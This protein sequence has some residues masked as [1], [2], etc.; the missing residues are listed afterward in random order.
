M[1]RNWAEANGFGAPD[2]GGLGIRAASFDTAPAGS[3][4]TARGND[5]PAECFPSLLC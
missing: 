5:D 2:L 3:G 4:N 1:K